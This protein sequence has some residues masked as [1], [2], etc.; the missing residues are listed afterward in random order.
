MRFD[1]GLGRVMY[2]IRTININMT[3]LVEMEEGDKKIL[4]LKYKTVRLVCV[5]PQ[6]QRMPEL[7]KAVQ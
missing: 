6:I 2:L 4:G 1:M 5:C 3:K 7:Q